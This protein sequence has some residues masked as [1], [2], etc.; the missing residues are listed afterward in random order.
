M[1]AL[2]C[3]KVRNRLMGAIK[4]AVIKIGTI[5]KHKQNW[6]ENTSDVRDWPYSNKEKTRMMPAINFNMKGSTFIEAKLCVDNQS[7]SC[8]FFRDVV[9]F[10]R[11]FCYN[12]FSFFFFLD[13]LKFFWDSS[14]FHAASHQVSNL[15]LASIRSRLFWRVRFV[16]KKPICWA[17]E[18]SL[19]KSSL[20]NPR[21]VIK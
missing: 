16:A 10:S 5:K 17:I 20:I 19:S 15:R 11:G 2:V 21:L 8:G 13:A 7:T 3:L 6:Y 12:Q 1:G 9:D 4:T 14:S 18:L